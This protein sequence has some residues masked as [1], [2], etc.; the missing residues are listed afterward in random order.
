MSV[1][2]ILSTSSCGSQGV[3]SNFQKVKSEF[4]Q[5]GQDLQTGNLKQAQADFATFS[6]DL[7]S[8]QQNASS[9]AAKDVN[10]LAQALQSGNLSQAQQAYATVQQD[11]QQAGGH[12]H[13]HHHHQESSQSSSGQSTVSQDVNT[14]GQDLKSGDIS[15]A[16]KVF[17]T[18]QKDLQQYT[19]N[20]QSS[21]ATQVAQNTN[22]SVSVSA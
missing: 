3:Q 21:N 2:G 12:H 4:S 8:G 20:Y 16:Q 22:S 15:S 11:V 9:P 19:N 7:P 13:R 18:L 1:S 14:L 6:K 10:A 5:L 17:T